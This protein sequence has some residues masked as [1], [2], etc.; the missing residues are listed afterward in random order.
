[1]SRELQHLFGSITV[2]PQEEPKRKNPNIAT[3]VRY[4]FYSTLRKKIFWRDSRGVVAIEG[5]NSAT[6]GEAF[7]I[8]IEYELQTSVELDARELFATFNLPDNSPLRKELYA[9]INSLQGAVNWNSNRRF[10]YTVAVTA[11]Q[12][13]AA[14]GVVYLRDFDLIIGYDH[15]REQAL[16]PYSHEGQLARMRHQM[17][18]G[19]QGA[20]LRFVLIDNT[21]HVAPVW[22]NNG[23]AV[24]EIKPQRDS[25]LA[26]GLYLFYQLGEGEE[27]EAEF[28]ALKDAKTKY[29]LFD[30][31]IEAIN[32]GKLDKVIE[33]IK[34]EH[35]TILLEKKQELAQ[36]DADARREK[37][38]LDREKLRLQTEREEDERRRKAE[39]EATD[40]RERRFQE[41]HARQMAQLKMDRERIEWDRQQ[42]NDGRKFDMDM[43]SRVQRDN[44]DAVKNLFEVLKIGVGLLGPLISAYVLY[45]GGSGKK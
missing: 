30:T 31:K 22:F 6:S 32:L 3:N 33:R 29:H 14:G 17:H 27:V 41:D 37:T 36:L 10:R 40:A 35:E 1:M 28:V 23:I 25:Q 12:I 8:T 39:Q 13:D 2:D 38:E 20:N 45:K 18:Y 24:V 44:N 11:A 42:L 26:D 16:H 43:R 4:E 21:G 19:N 5:P 9:R 34:I 15:L 7:Y